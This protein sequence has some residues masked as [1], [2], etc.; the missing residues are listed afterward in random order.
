MHVTVNPKP[1]HLSGDEVKLQHPL[2][3]ELL[4]ALRIARHMHELG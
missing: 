2:A 4:P 1:W 3:E